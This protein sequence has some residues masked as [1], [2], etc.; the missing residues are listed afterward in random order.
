MRDV[1][2]ATLCRCAV[3]LVLCAARA[4]R[5]DDPPPTFTPEENTIE[6]VEIH[7]VG[8]SSP[9]GIGDVRVKR[10]QLDASPRQQ[11]PEMLS[12]APGF[13]VDHE[14]NEGLGNDVHLRGFDLEHGAGIE[15]RVGS[16]PINAPLHILGQ[17]YADV[18][19]IIPEVVRG[20][21]VLEGTYD[22]RQG[23]AAIAGS[24]Y[25]D[26][27][28]AER[29]YHVKTSFGSFDQLRAL[30]IVAPRDLDEESFV[31]LAA[32]HSDGF[33]SRRASDSL[34]M[35]AQYG[36]DLSP[37]DHVRFT[38]TAYSASATLAGVVREDDVQAGRVGFYDSYGTFGENQ[39]VQSARVMLGADFDHE[40]HGGG[41]LEIEPWFMWTNLDARRNFTGD[42]L[43]PGLGDLFELTNLETAMGF[44]SRY[45]PAPAKLGSG[46]E[47]VIEPGVSARFGHTEQEKNLLA[48][49]DLTPWDRR[50][51]S[52]IEHARRR[53]VRRSRHAHR[54]AAPHLGRF[55][56]RPPRDRNGRS[57]R[58][59]LADERGRRRR[60]A[61]HGGV[62][63]DARLRGLGFLRR[64]VS[65]ARCR[66]AVHARS[67]RRGGASRAGQK[68]KMGDVARALRH[69]RR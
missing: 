36:F 3:V 47:L 32:R 43:G 65:L 50:L 40:T 19:F 21:R 13:F 57:P 63:S 18:G 15:M 33:G 28:V 1:H 46:V 11:T 60:A 31:A 20:M 38:G 16:I 5:A 67:L 37:S 56:R 39:S 69:V 61:H 4:A 12:A 42:L 44:S 14:D 23:D 54:Q 55:A 9:R 58:A 41:R 7:G 26:L 53:R 10:E 49:S 52:R 27:G 35:N 59:C 22:P 51:E 30:A 64:R 29:G 62:R 68:E 2:H 34:S 66:G 25:F 6:Q 48:S 17:G 8:W 45:H 24:A